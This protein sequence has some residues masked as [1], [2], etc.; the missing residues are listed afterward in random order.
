MI[1][2][3]APRRRKKE[4]IIFAM[5][6]RLLSIFLLTS[7]MILGAQS[8]DF[9]GD[10]AGMLGPLHLKLHLVAGHEGKLTGTADNPD[11]GISGMP[12]SNIRI[13]GQ[14]LS[15]SVPIVQGSWTGFLSSDG[16]SLSGMWNQGSPMPLNF[17]RVT[18][19]SGTNGESGS[20]LPPVKGSGD[21]K[22]D[23]YTFKFDRSGTMAQVFE[24]GKVVGTIL[25]VN[26]QQRVI[27]MPGTDAT[28]LQKSF[29]DY[30][31]FSA[32]NHSADTPVAATGPG[33]APVIVPAA[34]PAAPAVASAG[35]AL[36][37]Q[38]NGKADASRIQ[39]DDANHLVMVPRTDGFTVTFAGQDVRINAGVGRGFILRHQK[40]SAGRLLERS[41]DHRYD[42]G[43]SVAGGGIEFLHAEGGLIYD[44]GMGG[45]NLQENRQVMIAKQLS[46]MAV[47]AVAAVR[48]VP[49]HQ[50]FTPPGY[51]TL[52]EISQYRLRSDGSR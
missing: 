52:K 31:A 40:G 8:S 25:T 38:N 47:D 11:Q 18:G 27:A 13:D 44:S 29:D 50:K 14:A 20:A 30:R 7:A 37:L 12:C 19:S 46:A 17:T 21:V 3:T 26:G 32:R 1:T 6:S 35:A 34:T 5:L 43:G 9:A 45:M 36:G 41:F 39:F 49:G 48:Q 16:N 51:N 15:F 42:A 33:A 2:H 10:Y 4:R 24:S 22:W 23:D 28:K